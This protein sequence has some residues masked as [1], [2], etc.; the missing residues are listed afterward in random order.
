MENLPFSEDNRGGKV[1][2][3]VRV[4]LGGEMGWGLQSWFR[5]INKW[6][7]REMK[8]DSLNILAFLMLC[9]IAMMWIL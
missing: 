9:G 1:R 8:I 4:G 6:K 3:S 7:K 2:N 5:G